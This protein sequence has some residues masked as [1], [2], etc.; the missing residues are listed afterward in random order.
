MDV[1]EDE[2]VGCYKVEPPQ[3]QEGS[4]ANLPDNASLNELFSH[5]YQPEGNEVGSNSTLDEGLD[6]SYGADQIFEQAADDLNEN[7]EIAPARGNAENPNSDGS[8]AAG[9]GNRRRRAATVEEETL[10]DKR[11]RRMIRNRASA[12]R[13]R[14]R[15]QF[16]VEK[17]IIA[18]L[19]WMCLA[20]T[21]ANS[22]FE[23]LE[24][25]IILT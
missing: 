14:A 13:S 20:M 1:S 23:D 15:K 24:A 17:G 4:T 19:N 6:F 8:E 25:T 9:G 21:K 22:G 10:M 2:S 11:Q 12:Q 7:D 16:V 3:V 5:F 18:S